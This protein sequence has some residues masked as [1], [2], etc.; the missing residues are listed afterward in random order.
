MRIAIIG[1]GITGLSTAL[2]LNKLGWKAS[3]YE[4]AV[5]IN[6]I[7]AGIWLQPNAMQVLDW[8]GLKEQIIERGAL[9]DKMEITTPDLVPVK[10]IK[11][12][13]VQDA[14]GNQTVAIHRAKLQQLL[15]ETAQQHLDIHL[16]HAYVSHQQGSGK[17]SIQFSHASVEADVLLGCDGIHSA[18][19]RHIDPEASLRYTNQVC[20]RGISNY[21]LS[22]ELKNKGKEVWG[23]GVRFGFSNIADDQVYWFAVAKKSLQTEQMDLEDL[24]DLFEGFAPEILDMIA[25]TKSVHKAELSDLDRLDT[26]HQGNVCLLG[27]AAHATTPNMGQGACQGIED[28]Y[29]FANY[30]HQIRDPQQ[31]FRTF[32]KNRRRK[33]DYVVNN[34]WRFGHA[35]HHPIG[36]SFM[37]VLMK[38]TPESVLSKQMNRLYAVEA[39]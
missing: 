5:S 11:Q 33:V 6:E 27:D 15:L 18:V 12:A 21:P 8:L 35:A 2:A 13:V 19:R 28:A 3:V 37:K 39:F 38:L 23:N 14:H 25:R 9:L 4:R 7:G 1:G 36:R 34:S 24:P 20:W 31:A 10:K 29:Y 26:W 17:L 32:E 30:L 16:G 22:S